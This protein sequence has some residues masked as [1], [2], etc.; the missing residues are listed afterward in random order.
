MWGEVGFQFN[1]EEK[2]CRRSEPTS[3]R[4]IQ[5]QSLDNIKSIPFHLI[6]STF[7]NKKTK[8]R[9]VK[10]GAITGGKTKKTIQKTE[11]SKQTVKNN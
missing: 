7:I 10:K 11:L 1:E 9:T 4:S 6:R 8:R 3:P 2:K 5:T